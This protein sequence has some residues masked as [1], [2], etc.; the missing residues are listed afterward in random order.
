MGVVIQIECETLSNLSDLLPS[1]EDFDLPIP[2]L[3]SDM[4]GLDTY[5]L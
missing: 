2:Q 3:V 5:L 4:K 1:V